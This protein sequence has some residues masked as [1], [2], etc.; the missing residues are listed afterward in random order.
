LLKSLPVAT[1]DKESAKTLSVRELTPFEEK[2]I[3]SPTDTV[4]HF[5]S[6]FDN[7]SVATRKDFRQLTALNHR[8]AY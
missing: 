3:S 2:P 8:G 5:F 4:L 6:S 7:R 1:T